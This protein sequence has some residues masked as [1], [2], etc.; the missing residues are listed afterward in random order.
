MLNNFVISDA[1]DSSNKKNISSSL[2]NIDL[3]SSIN[4]RE[5]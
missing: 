1:N 3:V 2:T 5:S 4:S